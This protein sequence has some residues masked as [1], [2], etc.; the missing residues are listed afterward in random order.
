LIPNLQD[1]TLRNC[2]INCEIK[3]N[4]TSDNIKKE[5][6]NTNHME[7]KIKNIAEEI[8]QSLRKIILDQKE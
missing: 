7:D 2:Y 1:C 6:D 3:N 4:N 5:N 8:V